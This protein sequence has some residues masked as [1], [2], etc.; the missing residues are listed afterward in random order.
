M[1]TLR[2]Y[3][4]S[5]FK[6]SEEDLIKILGAFE[7]QKLKK[8]EYFLKEGQYCTK[9]AYVESGSFYYYMNID[10]NE[11]VC[12]FGFVNAWMTYNKSLMGK[13]PSDMNI[14][15]LEDAQIQ[16]ISMETMEK[17]AQDVP[18]IH[19]IGMQIM[20]SYFVESATR[21]ADLAN[22]NAAERY[23]KAIEENPNLLNVPQYH[24]A[25]FLGIKPQSLSRIRSKK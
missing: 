25:S 10:G 8:G 18:S 20:Q 11:K 4:R 21:A 24:L 1:S 6:I 17:L 22:L 13:I 23:Y 9:Q 2:E 7:I 19:L 5:N 15:A 3:L 16:W 12:D 14:Q